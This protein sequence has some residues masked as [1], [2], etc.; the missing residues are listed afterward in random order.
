MESNDYL[1]S[2]ESAHQSGDH[3][4]VLIIEGCDADLLRVSDG[5]LADGRF[6]ILHAA[7]LS[8]GIARLI[9]VAETTGQLPDA[10]TLDL[11]LP[12]SKG[13]ESFVRIHREFPNEPLVILTDDCDESLAVEAM[14]LGAQD[15][16]HK[17]SLDGGILIRSLLFAI[18]RNR[19]RLA[20]HRQRSVQREIDFA[21]EIQKHLLPKT[22][23]D[24]IGFDVAGHS[25]STDSTS[26]D[27]YDF[28]D[29]GDG[30]WDIVLADVCGHGI[31]PAMIT[32]G[33]RRLL[34]SCAA[35]HEDLGDLMT[36]ANRGICEDTF[37]SLFVTLFFARLNPQRMQLQ[38]IGAGHL[39]F[40]IDVDGM[41]SELATNGIP[42]GVDPDFSYHV[43]GVITMS[44]GQIALLM[45]DGI[46]E[47]QKDDEAPF[48]RERAFEIVH[49]YRHQSAAAISAQLISAVNEYCHPEGVQDDLTAVIIK[50][51]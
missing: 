12:D 16:V 42:T 8:E 15:Y 2:D 23:P 18:E 13:L 31:G 26:G 4:S 38:Y 20:E 30:K 10:I 47:A 29:H 6:S 3:Y 34:R 48:G 41:A 33:T 37:K 46:W 35:L 21:A 17:A 5:L 32:V 9:S 45:S 39:A 1:S 40:L 49:Q 7:T 22:S 51:R 25:E 11:N 14:R 43:D 50:A 36:I 19:R 27:F 24:L 28:I 44:S